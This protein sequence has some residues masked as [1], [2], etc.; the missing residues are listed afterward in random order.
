MTVG[1][2]DFIG[3]Q[4][5]DLERAAHFY[6]SQLGLKRAP[7]GPQ[8]AV[9]FATTPAFAVREALPDVDLDAVAPHPGAG[10]ILWLGAHDAQTLHDTLAN[11]GV[12][13]TIAPFDGPFGRTF[14]FTDPDG[15][16]VTVHDRV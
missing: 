5:R 9:V 12:T 6:E 15:Y 11:S 4:V 16:A 1:G 7:G 2:P 8:H 10:V 3:L 14:T 13:I